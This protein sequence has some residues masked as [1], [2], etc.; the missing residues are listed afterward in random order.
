MTK[1]VAI[2]RKSNLNCEPWKKKFVTSKGTIHFL[3]LVLY[4]FTNQNFNAEYFKGYADAVDVYTKYTTL[5]QTA[6]F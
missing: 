2:S 1:N 5:T 6:F 3:G 4:S